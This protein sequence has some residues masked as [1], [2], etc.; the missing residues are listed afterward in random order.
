M[1]LVF[2]DYG[3]V[4]GGRDVASKI[5]SKIESSKEIAILDFQDVRTV[6][7]SFADELIGKLAEKFGSALF[8]EK[9]NII[10]L[11][12]SNRKIFR[13]VISERNVL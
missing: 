3:K 11:D 4:L 13:F 10:N 6:S 2:K 8:K 9:I 7:H 1:N 12:K 5:R